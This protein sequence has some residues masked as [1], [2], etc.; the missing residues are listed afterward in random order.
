MKKVKSL[1]KI[2]LGLEIVGKRQDDY[3]E[4][5]TIFQTIDFYDILEFRPL[6]ANKIVLEGNNQSIAWDESNLI[7]K[8]ALLLKK[9][10]RVQQGIK[11]RVHKRIPPGRGLGGGSSNAAV[12]LATLN[13][14]WGLGIEK[15]ELKVL[16]QKLGADVPYFLEGGLCLGVGRGDTIVPLPDFKPYYC[17]VVL[18]PLSISTA[19]IYRQIPSSLTSPPKESKINRF[20]ESRNIG[21]L[22]NDLEEIVFSQYSHLR[23]IK[24]LIQSQGCELSLVSGSG[25]AVFGLFEDRNR[26]ELAYGESKRHYRTYLVETITR[27]R[28]WPYINYGV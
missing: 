21:S 17:L 15:S 4:L 6:A 20:L 10:G 26:A 5:R 16:A 14:I 18:P 1:A 27:D 8:A 24:R 11:V 9:K 13:Q 2:N 22:S 7:F 19:F 3:H 28:Y 23:N 12:T 25:S